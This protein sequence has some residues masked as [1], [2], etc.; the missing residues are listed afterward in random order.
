[1]RTTNLFNK[2]VH[3]KTSV[4][5]EEISTKDLPPGFQIER[6]KRKSEYSLIVIVGSSTVSTDRTRYPLSILGFYDGLPENP[7]DYPV[8]GIAGIPGKEIAKKA[9][10]K[11][12]KRLSSLEELEEIK[13]I[14][15]KLH[16]LGPHGWVA[17]TSIR[18]GRTQRYGGTQE[19]YDALRRKIEE[20]LAP[21][22]IDPSLIPKPL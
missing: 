12:T 14:S 9:A 1:M 7:G 2:E 13:K 21:I 4:L 11:V 19:T 17:V 22:S 3:E 5:P 6:N 20:R 10:T 16:D 8:E 18:Y 15:T